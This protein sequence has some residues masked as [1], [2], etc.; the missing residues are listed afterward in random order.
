MTVPS[1]LLFIDES[2]DKRLASQL[3]QRGRNAISAE[4]AGLTDTKDP[5]LL[6]AVARSYP[7]CVLLTGDDA[8]PGEHEE[9]ISS[10]GLTIATV[11]GQRDPGWGQSDWKCET[12]HRWV[13][14]V[15]NQPDGSRR[16]YS[17]H[18]HR[19]W[20]QRKGRKSKP[21]PQAG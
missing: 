9:L 3:A 15:E 5:P 12:V 21:R 19:A 17:P 1:R 8:M 11:D 4:W 18:R 10:L 14:V 20:S 13:H 16:R 2:L 6:R 7:G